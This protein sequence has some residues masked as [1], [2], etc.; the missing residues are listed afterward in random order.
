MRP[1]THQGRTAVLL[2]SGGQLC[3]RRA[4]WRGAPGGTWSLAGHGERPRS[5]GTPA[6]GRRRRGRRRLVAGGGP[7]AG[8]STVGLHG[9]GRP[10]ARW[11]ADHLQGTWTPHSYTGYI[12]GSEGGSFHKWNQVVTLTCQRWGMKGNALCRRW[13][14]GPC[15]ALYCGSSHAPQ[16]TIRFM[17]LSRTPANQAKL[18]TFIYVNG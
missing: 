3:R 16:E 10:G 13:F 12:T 6:G 11:A 15:R 18:F 1:W 2:Q 14:K 9:A 8:G 7:A 17:S 4:A 5:G